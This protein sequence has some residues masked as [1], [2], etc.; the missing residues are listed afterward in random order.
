MRNYLFI[1]LIVFIVSCKD[2][3]NNKLGTITGNVSTLNGD[4]AISGARIST[5]P[6]SDTI[7]TDAN[8][9]FTLSDIEPGNYYVTAQKEEFIVGLVSIIV[10]ENSTSMAIFK[11]SPVPVILTGQWQGRI[12]YYNTD[13]PLLLLF[14]K[15]TVDSI[16]G[17]M[18]ID[19]TAGADTFP[20]H[21]EIFYNNDSLHFNLAYTWGLC[22]AYDMWGSYIRKDSLRGSWKYKCTNDPAFTSPWSA[23]RKVK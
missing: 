21:S 3:N 1:L 2:D 7:F 9:N 6:A 5:V 19:F 4:T 18:I 8:G 12:Q 23:H 15:V 17:S 20:I 14:N 22:H 13:Y 10:M 11:L 16:Y